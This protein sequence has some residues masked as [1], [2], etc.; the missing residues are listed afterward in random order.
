MELVYVQMIL[1]V[2][3]TIYGI[4]RFQLHCCALTLK[5]GVQNTFWL[6]RSKKNSLF[7][8][9]KYVKILFIRRNPPILGIKLHN[10]DE[11]INKI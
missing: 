2:N 6:E 9:M 3:H 4:Q 7:K 1:I 10:I 11:F 5:E 8:Y